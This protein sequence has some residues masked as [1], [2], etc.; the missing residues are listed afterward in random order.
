MLK[1]RK[2]SGHR[3]PPATSTADKVSLGMRASDLDL[4]LGQE[5]DLESPRVPGSLFLGPS[6]AGRLGQ[7][8]HLT[9]ARRESKEEASVCEF[10]P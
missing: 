1:P 5:A 2:G 7:A 9:K 4:G 8:E 3:P 6:L 10:L